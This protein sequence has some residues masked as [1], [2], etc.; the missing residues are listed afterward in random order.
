MDAGILGT[1]GVAA[2]ALGSGQ[3]V[4]IPPALEHPLPVSLTVSLPVLLSPDPHDPVPKQSAGGD[5]PGRTQPV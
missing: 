2:R 1:E 4:L 5:V 3:G